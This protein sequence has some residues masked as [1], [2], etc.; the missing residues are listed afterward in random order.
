MF[1][2]TGIRQGHSTDRFDFLKGIFTSNVRDIGIGNLRPSVFGLMKIWF[3][4][5]KQ[6][7]LRFSERFREM[8]KSALVIS[9]RLKFSLNDRTDKN[10]IA[11]PEMNPQSFKRKGTPDS[12]KQSFKGFDTSHLTFSR[13]PRYFV[14]R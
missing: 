13:S 5:P 10:I 7:Q 9:K 2:E 1:A 14:S 12:L 6:G 11:R 4:V 3:R 8:D